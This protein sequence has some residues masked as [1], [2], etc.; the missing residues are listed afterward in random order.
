MVT[1]GVSRKL[2]MTDKARGMNTRRP[3][4]KAAIAS[5][6]AMST[7]DFEEDEDSLERAKVGS[8]IVR[9][10]EVGVRIVVC[11]CRNSNTKSA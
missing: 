8:G 6:M 9:P 4:Y 2:N 5:T 1:A 3:R 7:N 11:G 10:R